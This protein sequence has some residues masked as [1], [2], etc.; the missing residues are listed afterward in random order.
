MQIFKIFCE[1]TCKIKFI[2]AIICCVSF[3]GVEGVIAL[4]FIPLDTYVVTNLD[5]PHLSL[6]GVAQLPGVVAEVNRCNGAAFVVDRFTLPLVILCQGRKSHRLGK[7]NGQN[8]I[9]LGPCL[10]LPT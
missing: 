5:S 10:L 6:A 7:V 4:L 9:L 8:L 1:K 3:T 2:F